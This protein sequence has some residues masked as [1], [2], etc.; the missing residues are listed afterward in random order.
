[1]TLPLARDYAN[2]AIRVMAIAPGIFET[3]LM[4]TLPAK[5]YKLLK[6]VKNNK[7]LGEDIF[8]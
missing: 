3:P 6:I 7:I 2:S 4:Q 5:V 1:M 8:G